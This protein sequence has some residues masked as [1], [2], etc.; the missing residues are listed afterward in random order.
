MAK[1]DRDRVFVIDDDLGIREA[2][3]RLLRS[4]GLSAYGFETPRDFLRSP[5]RHRPGCLVLD[6]RLPGI[7]GLDFQRQ[8]VTE[9]LHLP[10]IFITGHG[11]IPMSVNAMKAGAV[12]FLSKP[13]RDQDLIDAINNALLRGRV[14]RREESAAVSIRRRFDALTERERE[15]MRLIVSGLPNKQAAGRL[16]TTEATVKVQRG[17]VMKKMKATSLPAL[18]RM[19]TT[20]GL[21]IGL[22]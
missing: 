15:V 11:D 17:Q 7:S 13:F 21:R 8:L 16:G 9:G 12:D 4:V 22:A 18:V 2:I 1:R 19:A 5:E 6:V 20:L 10:I 14:R 3:A